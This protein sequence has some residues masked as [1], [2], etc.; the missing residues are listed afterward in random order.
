M[1]IWLIWSCAD[2]T[3]TSTTQLRSYEVQYHMWEVSMTATACVTVMDIETCISRYIGRYYCSPVCW[4]GSVFLF[5]IVIV[6]ATI[7]LGIV[8]SK[9]RSD[10]DVHM[11]SVTSSSSRPMACSSNL[12]SS[13]LSAST[14]DDTHTHVSPKTQVETYLIACVVLSVINISLHTQPRTRNSV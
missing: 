7:P 12:E 2:G 9:I 14:N 3:V 13:G 6:L 4:R 10:D 8:E 11:I 1:R 5:P